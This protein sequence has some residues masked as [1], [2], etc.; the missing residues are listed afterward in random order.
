MSHNTFFTADT[1]FGHKGMIEF[2][3]EDG[4]KLR[5][6][7]TIEEHDETIIQNWNNIIRPMDRV[8]HLGDCVIN[9][10][11]L[12]TLSRLNGRKKLIRGNH[13][14]FSLEDYTPYFED[15][16]GVYVLKDVIL[17]HIPVHPDCLTSRF[18]T[19]VHGH[20]HSKRVMERRPIFSGSLYEYIGHE[21][22]ID[23]KYLCVS[24]EHT[25]FTPLSIDE[26]RHRIK[27]NAN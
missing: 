4:T 17:S 22:T 24:L 26:V 25:N 12:I 5:P 18:G 23:P 15:V 3:R 19:N 6:F 27:N 11:C 16:Y 20:L 21:Y 9:R 7:S 1:H 13:D 2:L 8:Y 10:R 14:L